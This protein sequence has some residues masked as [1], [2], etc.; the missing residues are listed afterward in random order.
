MAKTTATFSNIKQLL[1]DS[2]TNPLSIKL[3]GKTHKL[4]IKLPPINRINKE[5]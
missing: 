1:S 4:N 3:V 2:K 5:D